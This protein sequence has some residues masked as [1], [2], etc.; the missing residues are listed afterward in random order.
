MD[1]TGI[2]AGL[3]EVA[4][5]I[6]TAQAQQY[7]VSG[8]AYVTV[9]D[10]LLS[11]QVVPPGYKHGIERSAI[12]KYLQGAQ[13]ATLKFSIDTDIRAKDRFIINDRWFEAIFVLTA[14]TLEVRR[15]VLAREV[16]LPERVLYL[17]LKPDGHDSASSIEPL[18]EI[19]RIMPFAYVVDK[20]VETI[21]ETEGGGIEAANLKQI[22]VWEIARSFLSAANLSR[23][24]YC[25]IVDSDVEVTAE[26]ARTRLYPRYRFNGSPSIE[27]YA[28]A[29][30]YPYSVTLVE[31]R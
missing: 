17:A 26:G 24:L 21:K 18:P 1:L 22:A 30:D 4:E 8:A 13:L 29:R 7:R 2:V 28:W 12:P 3:K 23:L 5:S 14:K 31:E 6:Q 19:V 9:G 10:E 25:L 20:P 15:K 11:C 16:Q 27:S